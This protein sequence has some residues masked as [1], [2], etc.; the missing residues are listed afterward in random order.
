MMNYKQLVGK[1]IMVA[2][3]KTAAYY[4]T[5]DNEI[6]KQPIGRLDGRGSGFLNVLSVKVVYKP[7]LLGFEPLLWMEVQDEGRTV[8]FPYQAG[9]YLDSNGALLSIDFEDGVQQAA[10]EYSVL[11]DFLK[12]LKIPPFAWALA[13]LAALYFLSK[14]F[15]K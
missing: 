9:G 12:K 15:K 14:I 2:P 10:G 13:A 1:K 11:P 6:N 8:W 3:F 4:L 5:P 7:R